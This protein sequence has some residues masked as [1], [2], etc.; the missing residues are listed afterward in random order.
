MDMDQQIRA[1][2]EEHKCSYVE[3]AEQYGSA[4]K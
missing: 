3:A 4:K 1:Y 2:A